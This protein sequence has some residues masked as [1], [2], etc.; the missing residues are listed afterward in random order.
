MWGAAG[1][2]VPA[3]P[4]R[5][6]GQPVPCGARGFRGCRSRCPHPPPL[7]QVDP[8]GFYT[9]CLEL[10]CWDSDTGLLPPPAACDTFA[11]YARDC[12]QH[13]TY[14]SWRRPGFCGR[15]LAGLQHRAPR[16][17]SL[18]PPAAAPCPPQLLLHVS[19]ALAAPVALCVPV[20]CTCTPHLLVHA[21]IS[22]VHPSFLCAPFGC[23]HPEGLCMHP[24]VTC[25][26]VAWA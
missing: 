12:A 17:C 9:A 24:S 13:Q 15:D 7:C 5:G 6:E 10:L 18:S 3:V 14:V 21:P 4:R 19:P 8:G 20:V 25:T 26:P 16:C 22:P 11:A 23:L 2:A 1:R